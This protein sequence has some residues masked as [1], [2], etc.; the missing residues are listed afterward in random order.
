MF[1]EEGKKA[2][3]NILSRTPSLMK[4]HLL[5][6]N[7]N[8]ETNLQASPRST[9]KLSLDSTTTAQEAVKNGRVEEPEPVPPQPLAQPSP[10]LTQVLPPTKCF[11]IRISMFIMSG[12]HYCSIFFYI[13]RKKRAPMI[14][15]QLLLPQQSLRTTLITRWYLWY[16]LKFHLLLILPF[17]AFKHIHRN[18]LWAF[19]IHDIKNI[20]D[21]SF[22]NYFVSC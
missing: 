13:S 22:Y 20:P 17:H 7:N 19:H 21:M 1:D 5:K 14:R 2:H 11:Q 18:S 6:Q 4:S 10:G 9:P 12:V 8:N 16:T 3:S 15:L